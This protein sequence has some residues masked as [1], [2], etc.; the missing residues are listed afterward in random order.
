MS[1]KRPTGFVRKERVL[2][3]IEHSIEG[4]IE[5]SDKTNEAFYNLDERLEQLHELE[6]IVIELSWRYG[7]EN[8]V[9]MFTQKK[10][11]PNTCKIES[12]STNYWHERILV[13][14]STTD[15]SKVYIRF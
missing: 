13:E 12:V 3:V 2:D 9:Y 14:E 4:V 7:E 6:D 8:V 10:S 1:G 11:I 15:K 5:W